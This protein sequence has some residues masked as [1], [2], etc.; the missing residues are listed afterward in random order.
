MNI[1]VVS[2]LN[3]KPTSQEL[4][5]QLSRIQHENR[6]T[7][8]IIVVDELYNLSEL[9]GRNPPKDY[10]LFNLNDF[11]HEKVSITDGAMCTDPNKITVHMN[12]IDSS[13]ILIDFG[14]HAEK[15]CA[16][17]ILK[18]SRYS[19][20]NPKLQKR[21]LVFTVPSMY[22]GTFAQKINESFNN[23]PISRISTPYSDQ[24]ITMLFFNT[25]KKL[26]ISLP[27][28]S[29]ALPPIKNLLRRTYKRL[30]KSAK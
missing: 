1:F 25:I 8:P 22:L 27:L 23:L 26:S 14:Q 20:I 30:F 18:L 19:Y 10:T 24:I 28:P 6:K 5:S 13:W 3:P 15:T 21:N 16:E 12:K 2:Q 9:L 29:G 17:F 4:I 7:V 11:L